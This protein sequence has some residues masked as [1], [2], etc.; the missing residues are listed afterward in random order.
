MEDN[1]SDAGSIEAASNILAVTL[2]RVM[3]FR[4]LIVL[5]VV[6]GSALGLFYSLTLPDQFQSV[7]KLYV[8][9]GARD[10]IT[11][12]TAF[13][14]DRGSSSRGG[15]SREAVLNELQV[16]S[17]PLL[18]DK[19]VN[20]VGSRV[21]LA[22][23]D[24]AAGGEAVSW[25]GRLMSG[26]QDWWFDAGHQPAAPTGFRPDKI[27]AMRLE[28]SLT[29]APESGTNVIAFTYVA[30]SP[31]T[32]RDVVNAVLES[33]R[34]VHSDVIDTMSSLA[35]IEGEM[36]KSELNARAAEE[37]LREFHAEKGIHSFAT[38]Y[39]AVLLYVDELARKVD[40]TDILIGQKTA[41]K[42]VAVALEQIRTDQRITQ[43]GANFVLNPDYTALTD[44]LKQL[45]L[46]DAALEEKKGG[47][48]SDDYR[49][50]KAGLAMLIAAAQAKV[51]VTQL[52]LSV[53]GASADNPL[54][55]SIAQRLDDLSTQLKGLESVKSKS[56]SLLIAARAR[57]TEFQEFAPACRTLELDAQQ[58][59]TIADGLIETVTKMITVQRLEKANLSSVK[60]L[61]R[62]TNEPLK[63]APRRERVVFF[64]AAVGAALGVA[65]ALLFARLDRKVRGRE[66]LVMLGVP[67]ETVLHPQRNK[68]KLPSLLPPALAGVGGDLPLF[69]ASMPYDR[70]A[71]GGLKVA[72]VPCASGVDAG[73]AAATF[74]VGLAAYAGE[75]VAYVSCVE[76]ETWLSSRLEISA[77]VGWTDVLAG[78][79]ELEDA[80][81]STSVS[82]LSYLSV[83]S[84]AGMAPHPMVGMGFAALLEALA[85]S[86]RFVI[87]ELPDLASAPGSRV[88]LGV[89]DAVELVVHNAQTRKEQVAHAV[90]AVQGS[91]ARL[92]GAV[93]ED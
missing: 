1:E 76:G 28:Q 53:E 42:E 54:Y 16:L 18:F 71:I 39:P 11:P 35:L 13:S 77:L 17:G 43:G 22:P 25:G 82:A 4:L 10:V 58:K 59:R 72:F 81:V 5:T 92:L 15:G 48:P 91:G 45:W 90:A 93:L 57:L 44:R 27:A 50:R 49:N 78:E 84:L 33:A 12:A 80:L 14:D 9:P 41:E 66:D 83:G 29:I 74:A 79:H 34:D 55:V 6:F 60:I 24:P 85:G 26:F 88:V 70:Q 40:D 32:A 69:W 30:H 89:V 47:M 67:A 87:V 38:E 61:H 7:G 68:V 62:A 51:K 52:Q 73:R 64:G 3:R 65:L 8:R 56:G 23:Y 37:A 63:V 20:R 75:R 2:R 21:I 46:R 19:V 31:E 86:H 36:K